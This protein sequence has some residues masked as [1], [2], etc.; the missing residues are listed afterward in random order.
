MDD[1]ELYYY[2]KYHG[3]KDKT[4]DWVL[5]KK[6]KEAIKAY[7]EVLSLLA[8]EK[9]RYEKNKEYELKVKEYEKT[10][11]KYYVY[12][13]IY[14]VLIANIALFFCRHYF[15]ANLYGYFALVVF[16]SFP[17]YYLSHYLLTYIRSTR[18]VTPLGRCNTCFHVLTRGELWMIKKLDK[19]LWKRMLSA[20]KSYPAD[21]CPRCGIYHFGWYP[22]RRPLQFYRKTTI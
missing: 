7:N 8:N 18:A 16:W 12:I 15:D 9:R 14:I 19:A 11:K 3:W 20:V 22:G 1:E 21:L 2:M 10:I 6:D 17:L 4:I 5:S 13:S